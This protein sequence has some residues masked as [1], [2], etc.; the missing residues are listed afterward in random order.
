MIIVLDSNEYINY[1]NKETLLLQK[2]FINE[3]LSI[4][5]NDSIIREIL[6]NLRES[7]RKEFY[8]I[9]FKYKMDFYGQMPPFFI[10]EK[11]RNLGLKK[12]DIIIAAFCEHIN[13]D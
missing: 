5:I 10:Y 7:Q 9:L 4:C 3:D 13:A 2:I 6:R 12:G 1:I 11:Y 8:N